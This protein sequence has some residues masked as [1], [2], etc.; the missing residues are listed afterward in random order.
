MYQARQHVSIFQA[1]VVMRTKHV[2]R[3]HGRVASSILLIIPSAKH[4]EPHR[5]VASWWEFT[6]NK[7]IKRSYWLRTTIILLA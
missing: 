6:Q 7:K 4:T 3:D 5:Q 1:E 2:G